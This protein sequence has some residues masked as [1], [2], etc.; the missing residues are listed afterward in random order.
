MKNRYDHTKAAVE[1]VDYPG[2]ECFH[3][4]RPEGGTIVCLTS[5]NYLNRRDGNR[6]THYFRTTLNGVIGH[7]STPKSINSSEGIAQHSGPHLTPHFNWGQM[8]PIR[9]RRVFLEISH[10]FTEGKKSG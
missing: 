2:E 4:L 9:A 3:D 6:A 10:I 1:T 8:F 7:I 5:V